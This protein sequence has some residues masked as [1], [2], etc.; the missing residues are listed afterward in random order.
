MAKPTQYCKVKNNN[1]KKFFLNTN[2]KLNKK[3][4]KFKKNFLQELPLRR[5]T[6]WKIC[7]FKRQCNIADYCAIYSQRFEDINQNIKKIY[8]KIN[9]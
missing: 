6:S 7:V 2:K 9:T 3:K 5:I 1:D 4:K 8:L